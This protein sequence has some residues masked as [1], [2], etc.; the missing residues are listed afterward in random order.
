[1]PG[2]VL[3]SCTDVKVR[4]DRAAVAAA[5]IDLHVAHVAVGGDGGRVGVVQVV[6]HHHGAVLGPPHGVKLVV[7]V[8]LAQV[9]EGLRGRGGEKGRVQ[10]RRADLAIPYPTVSSSFP[11][12]GASLP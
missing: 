3:A 7:P 6:Q 5:V 1:M 8:A 4:A 9:E 12:L 2:P 11:H 10:S